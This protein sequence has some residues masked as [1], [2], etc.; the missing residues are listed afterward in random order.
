[1]TTTRWL[2]DDHDIYYDASDIFSYAV[3]GDRWTDR[4]HVANDSVEVGDVF[5]LVWPEHRNQVQAR[6]VAVA[7]DAD[8]RPERPSL[9]PAYCA[10]IMEV[11]VENGSAMCIR[12]DIESAVDIDHE[13]HLDGLE[14]DSIESG[15]AIPDGL[16][17]DLDRRWHAHVGDLLESGKSIRRQL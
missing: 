11:E 15:D 6:A 9:G 17:A 3:E 14:L 4:W 1:M 5:Y 12:I 8:D 16:A 13:L 7:A 10:D 2:R